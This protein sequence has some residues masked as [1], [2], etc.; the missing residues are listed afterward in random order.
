M[1][2]S[3]MGS[4]KPQ[5]DPR[6]WLVFDRLPNDLQRS[7]DSRSDADITYQRTRNWGGPWS[8]SATQTE[9]V[10][11]EHLGFELPADLKT[12]VHYLTPGVRHRSWPQ[13]EGAAS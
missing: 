4:Q 11:L 5:P 13:L 8:R 6:G 12:R 7:E 9:R 10:L 2:S 3:E 1:A